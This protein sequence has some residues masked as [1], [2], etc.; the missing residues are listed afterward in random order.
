[1][2][3]DHEAYMIKNEGRRKAV[4]VITVIISFAAILVFNI[5]TPHMSD[6]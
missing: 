3:I 5:L 1:M 6:D 4:F 2:K